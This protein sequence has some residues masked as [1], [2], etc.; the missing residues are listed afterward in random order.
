MITILL[1]FVAFGMF[2]LA[3]TFG[4]YDH[5]K[6]CTNSISRFKYKICVCIKSLK[7]MDNDGATWWD[8]WSYKLTDED[9]AKISK[10]TGHDFRGVYMPSDEGMEMTNIKDTSNLSGNEVY[11]PYATS[12]TGL[13]TL[14][15]K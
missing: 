4:T 13:L 1:S 10:E 12:I 3:D 7:K 5:I 2:A 9:V 11:C 15:R 6:T 8:D 14:I